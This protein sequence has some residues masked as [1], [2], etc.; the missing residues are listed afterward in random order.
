MADQRKRPKPSSETATMLMTL[1]E[2]FIDS[3]PEVQGGVHGGASPLFIGTQWRE[4]GLDYVSHERI[5]SASSRERGLLGHFCLLHFMA[6]P[7]FR[8]QCG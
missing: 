7:I 3:S 1:C 6:T 8:N 4:S 5:G 2:R